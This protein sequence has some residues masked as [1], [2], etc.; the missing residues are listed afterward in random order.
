[1]MKMSFFKSYIVII[2]VRESNWQNIQSQA[3][4]ANYNKIRDISIKR[5]HKQTE[6]DGRGEERGG[7]EL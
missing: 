7:K 6:K 5:T 3:F 2:Q 4:P 1:M